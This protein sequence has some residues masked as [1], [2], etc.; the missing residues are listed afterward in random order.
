[1]DKFYKKLLWINLALFLIV[2][3]IIGLIVQYTDPDW[4]FG[5]LVFILVIGETVLSAAPFIIW[6]EASNSRRSTR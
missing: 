2:P 3:F 1:M 6:A 4:F 5:P